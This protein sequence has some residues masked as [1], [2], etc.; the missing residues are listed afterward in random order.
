MATTGTRLRHAGMTL[1]VVLDGAHTGGD[2]GVCELTAPRGTGMPLHL[3]TREDETLVVLAG[4]VQ[5]WCDGQPHLVEAP[6]ALTCQ[7]GVPHRFEVVS[8][9]ARL[10]LVISPAGFEAT[11]EATSVD[12][13][14]A[15]PIDPDDVA[16]LFTGAGVSLLGRR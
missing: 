4:T 16:A 12:G 10:L 11:L 1:R 8:E 3:H 13:D 2:Y 15:E 5:V 14:D 7:R 6:R 9:E